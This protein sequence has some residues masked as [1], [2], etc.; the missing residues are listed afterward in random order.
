M[1]TG[2]MVANSDLGAEAFRS[3]VSAR[4]IEAVCLLMVDSF[5]L[6][7]LMQVIP[8][9]ASSACTIVRFAMRARMNEAAWLSVLKLAGTEYF[10][11]RSRTSRQPLACRFGSGQSGDHRDVF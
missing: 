4:A 1:R 11:S 5:D 6:E 8:S 3:H 9:D 2:D 10:L 7:T